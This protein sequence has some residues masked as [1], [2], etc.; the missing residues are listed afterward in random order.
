[1][2]RP[3]SL[4][5]V[6]AASYTGAFNPEPLVVVGGGIIDPQPAIANQ[7]AAASPFA[8][9]TAAATAHNSLVTKVNAILAAL[10]SAGVIAP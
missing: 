2:P 3:V 5:Q 7:S 4:T 8:D 6:S 9:L 1:M 10:R